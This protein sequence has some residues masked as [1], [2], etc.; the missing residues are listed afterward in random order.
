MKTIDT[1]IHKL[2]IHRH[3]HAYK[4]THIQTNI[5]LH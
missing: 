4:Q 3:T 5:Q 2:H 1:Q